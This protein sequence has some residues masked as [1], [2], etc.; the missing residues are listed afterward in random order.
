M[1]IRIPVLAVALSIV[2]SGCATR[3]AEYTEPA[4]SR[5]IVP[6]KTRTAPKNVQY[7]NRKGEVELEQLRFEVAKLR[8][9]VASV[10][11]KDKNK[12]TDPVVAT[13]YSGDCT[14]DAVPKQDEGQ[15]IRVG[16]GRV[17]N[18]K[19]IGDR[20]YATKHEL[21]LKNKP[22]DVVMRFNSRLLQKRW[23]EMLTS[24][25]VNNKFSSKG[26]DDYLIYLGRYY[27]YDSAVSRKKQI[28]DKTGA[29][30]VEIIIDNN[31]II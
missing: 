27:N 31:L 30:M 3:V 7:V 6:V 16:G 24:I 19:E 9:A 18:A 8:E 15:Y 13:S 10:T 25:G 28:Q 29:G 23:W 26:R 20:S 2:V 12:S 21:R 22:M 4:F 11:S 17:M 14:P 5:F 1:S